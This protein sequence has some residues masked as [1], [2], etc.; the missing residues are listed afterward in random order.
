MYEQWFSGAVPLELCGSV[1]RLG[2]ANALI[3][4]FISRNY[5]DILDESLTGIGGTDYSVQFVPGYQAPSVPEVSGAPSSEPSASETSAAGNGGAAE[6]PLVV[7]NPSPSAGSGCMGENTFANFVV[8]AENRFAYAAAKAVAEAPGKVHNPLF[9]YGVS[10]VGKTHLLNSIAA[11]ITASDPR[12]RVRCTTCGELLDEFYGD[13]LSRKGLKDFLDS[14]RDLD[15]LLVD[16]V[17]MISGRTQMQIEFFKVFETLCRRKRQ[18]VIASDRPPYEIADLDTRLSSRF[19]QDMTVEICPPELEARLAI[20]KMLRAGMPGVSGLI[21]DEVL[22]F[23]A[24]NIHSN[25][26]ALR[27]C[28]IRLSAFASMNRTPVDLALAEELLQGQ[29]AQE[30]SCR[31]VTIETIQRAVA[32]VFEVSMNDLLGSCR[33]R[34]LAEPR[35]VAMYLCRELTDSSS[36]EVGAAFGRNHATVL[37]AEKKVPELCSCDGD[38]RRAVT[39]LRR[40]LQ[41]KRLYRLAGR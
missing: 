32:A 21:G 24:E 12:R 34:A 33:S 31:T 10:G 26:R 41:R 39:L 25:V 30:A 27:G 7:V 19:S 37:H 23:V 3:S 5:G 6:E 9:I 29:L 40:Q 36:S 1:L 18:I 38:I 28:F 11:Y 2:I 15:V 17:Q 20:L 16:D 14:L 22:G 4:D 13:L 35:M 8:G